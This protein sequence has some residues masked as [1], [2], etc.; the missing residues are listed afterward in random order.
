MTTTA[1]SPTREAIAAAAGRL[2]AAHGYAG[3][4]VR[5]VA[6]AA[7]V[8]PALVI[9]H[10]GSKER[11]FLDTTDLAGQFGGATGGDLSRLGHNL[12]RALVGPGRDVRLAAYRSMMR[13]TDSEAVRGR[14]LEALE[15]MFVAPLAPRL[16]G[17]HAE[18]RARLIGAQVSGL[19][20]ALTMV[21]D[22]VVRTADPDLLDRKSVV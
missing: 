16:P 20:D 9:R 22:P 7:G 2:F 17:P 1:G 10:F 13:A 12:V 21:G 11:L 4:S 6:A 14:L 19:L 3:T 18:L 8:D 15:E 5:A